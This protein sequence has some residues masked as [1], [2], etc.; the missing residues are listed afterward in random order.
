MIEGFECDH[1]FEFICVLVSYQANA[2]DVVLEMRYKSS[3]SSSCFKLKDSQTAVF[4]KVL[5]IK[6]YLYKFSFLVPI[7]SLSQ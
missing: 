4:Y 3:S 1:T 7:Q 6:K 5:T 2:S